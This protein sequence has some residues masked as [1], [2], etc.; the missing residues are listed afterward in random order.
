M[1]FNYLMLKAFQKTLWKKEKLQIHLFCGPV[2]LN[3]GCFL[4][5]W[6]YMC[7]SAVLEKSLASFAHFHQFFNLLYEAKMLPDLGFYFLLF[8]MAL[9]LMMLSP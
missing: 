7:I 3:V 2:Q 5:N 4:L 1:N 6:W 9:K 8:K